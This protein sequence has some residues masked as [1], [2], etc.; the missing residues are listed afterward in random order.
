LKNSQWENKLARKIAEAWGFDNDKG[1]LFPNPTPTEDM[2]EGSEDIHD[3]QPQPTLRTRPYGQMPL[4]V[5]PEYQGDF[6]QKLLDRF[7]NKS[8]SDSNNLLDFSMPS[9]MLKHQEEPCPRDIQDEFYECNRPGEGAG[10]D[11]LKDY[12]KRD[13]EPTDAPEMSEDKILRMRL[14]GIP[15]KT[16]N[17]VFRSAKKV[18]SAFLK[19]TSRPDPQIVV[20]KYLMEV[21]P[22]ELGDQD[23]IRVAKLIGEFQ[24]TQIYTESKGR[25][26][27]DHSG[28]SVRLFRAEPRVGRWTFRTSSGKDTYITI[29][30]FIPDR[31]IV[32]TTKLH[33]RVSCTCP[34]FLFWGAQYNAVMGDYFYGKIRPKFTPPKKR[35]PEGRFLVCK[36]ILA[37]IPIVSNYRLQTVSEEV[38]K[39]LKGPAKI[40]LIKEIPEEKLHIPKDL[41]HIGDL[42][43]MKKI[44]D[45]WEKMS[46]IKKRTTILGLKDP[47]EVAF[48][49]HRF[50]NTATVFV[51]E[52]LKGMALKEKKAIVREEAKNLLQEII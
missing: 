48:M 20:A 47:E 37:C 41:L 4:V 12:Y 52:K 42:P 5:R 46:R 25:R 28:V 44:I 49:A 3:I 34:S 19:K 1:N 29:F 16:F 22:M 10:Y 43:E 38:R 45:Q 14:P 33:V 21:C 8:A 17:K 32:E 36:H 13:W 26:K 35:D 31:R 50:P 6:L 7:K 39:R 40:E 9:E 15:G 27:P 24:N 11:V 51:V 23:N 2:E 18:L 30:Q